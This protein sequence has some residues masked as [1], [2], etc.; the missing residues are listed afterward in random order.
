MKYAI[1]FFTPKKIRLKLI[2]VNLWETIPIFLFHRKIWKHVL[3]L[4]WWEY[5]Y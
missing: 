2:A 4:D 1:P 3:E 5:N